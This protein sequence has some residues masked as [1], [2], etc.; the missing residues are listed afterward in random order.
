MKAI[1]RRWD[2]YA[3]LT[4]SLAAFAFILYRI[5]NI[6]FTMDEWGMWKYSIRPGLEPLITFQHQLPQSHFFQG[7]FAMP[8]VKWLPF[9]PCEA[10]RLPSILMFPIYI[11]A[12]FHLANYF[13]NSLLRFLFFCTWICPQIILEYFGMARGYAFMFAGCVASFVGIFETYNNKNTEIQKERWTKFSILSAAVALLS[14]LTFSYGYFMVT[15]L[16]LLRYW[17]DADGTFWSKLK[18]TISRGSFVIWTC[19]VLGVF[20]LPRYLILRHSDSMQWG[21]INNVISDSFTTFLDCLVCIPQDCH[22]IMNF[23]HVDLI[24][25]YVIFGL[26]LLNFLTFLISNIIHKIPFKELLH[27]PF[28]LASI[29]FFGI[30]AMM[31]L[32]FWIFN[33]QLPTR[34][35]V[36]YFWPIIVMMLGFGIAEHKSLFI[37]IINVITMLFAI[38][39]SMTKYNVD[40]IVEASVDCQNKEI[41]NRLY[42]LSKY[43]TPERPMF[44]GITDCMRY[45][46][47]Y[48]LEYEHKM[49]ENPATVNNPIVKMFG[50]KIVLYSLSYGYPQPFPNFW[51]H[52]PFSPDYYVLSPYEPGQKPDFRLMEEKPLYE[53]DICKTAIYKSKPVEER[54]LGCNVQFCKVCQLFYS[55]ISKGPSNDQ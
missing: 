26:L 55:M 42:E 29:S 48:Y 51:H 53:F 2:F 37:R 28:L 40:S 12:G 15:I 25:V 5:F 32:L 3:C 14:V 30:V 39:F 17:I 33:M 46:I 38:E 10:S 13:K 43:Y 34:R 36:L 18:E 7:L 24:L 20:Y 49:E 54:F 6:S 44:V 19:V 41:A 4:I 52:F 9:D 47:W 8:F 11:W 22:N 45:T 1:F 35:T 50:D 31:Q 27:S 23:G 21:G 16:L